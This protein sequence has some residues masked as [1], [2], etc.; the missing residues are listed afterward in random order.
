MKLYPGQVC[1]ECAEEALTPV[2][3]EEL[4]RQSREYTQWHGICDVC[5]EEKGVTAP[6]NYGWPKFDGH[7]RM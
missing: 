3:W 4:M 5:E 6:R 2:E 7:D 1:A